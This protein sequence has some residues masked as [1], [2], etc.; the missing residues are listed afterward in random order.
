MIRFNHII[1]TITLMTASNVIAGGYDT[2][3]EAH[4]DR[5]KADHIINKDYT[6]LPYKERIGWK[7]AD[8]SVG[9]LDLTKYDEEYAGYDRVFAGDGYFSVSIKPGEYAV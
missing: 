2:P 4:P 8:F 5:G 1:L 9:D 7:H 3:F 6:S